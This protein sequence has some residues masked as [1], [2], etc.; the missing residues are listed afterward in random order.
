MRICKIVDF[1]DPVDYR[2]KLKECE[3]KDK[4][5]RRRIKLKEC[6]KKDKYHDLAKEL[7]KTMDHESDNC[8]K[9]DSSLWYSN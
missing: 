9:C 8:T 4:L 5:P 3:K 6:E 1:A 7:K 2:I